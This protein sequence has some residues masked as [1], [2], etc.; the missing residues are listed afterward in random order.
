MYIQALNLQNG[1][2]LNI[3]SNMYTSWKLHYLVLYKPESLPKKLYFDEKIIRKS[4]V[5]P[6]SG[7][8]MKETVKLHLSEGHTSF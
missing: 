5:R 1:K 6:H 3:S 8:L 2:V 4:C 7:L